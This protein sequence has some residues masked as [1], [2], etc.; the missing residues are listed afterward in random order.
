MAKEDITDERLQALISMP[1]RVLNPRARTK[2]EGRH[3]R[4]DFKVASIDGLHEFALYT[5]QS[6]KLKNSYSAGIRW[7][8]R[9]EEAL[10]LVRC[11][12]SS[13]EHTNAIER[14]IIE[15]HCHVHVAT[16]R[17]LSASKRDEG[18]ARPTNAYSDLDGAL[19]HLIDMCNIMGFSED[20]GPQTSLFDHGHE[21]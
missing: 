21:P 19:L 2:I 12:G 11:N 4:V 14:E 20:T 7:L 17:Y 10:M 16:E 13:H 6:T 18:F 9:G 1:K 15:F 8:P 5:R 3:E